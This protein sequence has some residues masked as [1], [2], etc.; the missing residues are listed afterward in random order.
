MD[1]F[2]TIVIVFLLLNIAV[3]LI[4]VW[5][6]PTVADRLLTTQLFG[7]TGMAILLVLAGYLEDPDFLNVAITFN[8]LAILLVIGLV[9]VWKKKKGESP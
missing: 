6:G 4:R 8:V 5:R 7:T 1:V 2:F 9:K 3:G